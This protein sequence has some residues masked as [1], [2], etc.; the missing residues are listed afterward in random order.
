MAASIEC[1]CDT[2]FTNDKQLKQVT[3]ANVIYI[4]DL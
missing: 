4:G 2:F 3:E 1:G